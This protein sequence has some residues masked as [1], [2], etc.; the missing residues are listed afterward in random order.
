MAKKTAKIVAK[1][2]AKIEIRCTPTFKRRVEKAATIHSSANSIS[3][4]ARIQLRTG[5]EITLRSESSNN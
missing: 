1:K 4:Y 5:N 3:E 2:T